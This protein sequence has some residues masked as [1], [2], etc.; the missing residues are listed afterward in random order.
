MQ[1]YG[2]YLK[3]CGYVGGGGGDRTWQVLRQVWDAARIGTWINRLR[4]CE[5]DSL[6]QMETVLLSFTTAT[7]YF[8]KTEAPPASRDEFSR[9]H[10]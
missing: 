10:V 2:R 7:G 4:K 8:L 6:G 3:K 5:L 9:L 1:Y